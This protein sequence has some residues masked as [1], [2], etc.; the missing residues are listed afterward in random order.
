MKKLKISFFFVKNDHKTY[1]KQ[2]REIVKKDKDF[3]HSL[4]VTLLVNK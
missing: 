1:K 4:L 2:T 3:V